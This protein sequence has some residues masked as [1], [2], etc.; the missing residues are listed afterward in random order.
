MS[1][2]NYAD[3]PDSYEHGSAFSV[4]VAAAAGTAAN[5]DPVSAIILADSTMTYPK[6]CVHLLSH[7]MAVHF[8][9]MPGS[10]WSTFGGPALEVGLPSSLYAVFPVFV[11]A[12]WLVSAATGASA[13]V[14]TD[15]ATSQNYGDRL[16]VGSYCIANG[17]LDNPRLVTAYDHGSKTVTISGPWATSP[18]VG[19]YIYFIPANP[20]LLAPGMS[21]LR[22]AFGGNGTLGSYTLSYQMDSSASLDIHYPHVPL[23]LGSDLSAATVTGQVIAATQTN[24]PSI[25]WSA[26]PMT[27][28]GV[29]AFQ[30]S[31][32]D[33]LITDARLTSATWSVYRLADVTLPLA[34]GL[35]YQQ[36]R[37]E[38]YEP[39]G[40]ALVL[41]SR[42]LSN[43]DRRGIIINTLSVGGY[44]STHLQS[45]HGGS[46]AVFAA[47]NPQIVIL[48]YG[49]N[50][51]G[52]PQYRTAQQYYDTMASNID[53]LKTILP[54]AVFVVYAPHWRTLGSNQGEYDLYAGALYQLALNGIAHKFINMRKMLE[55]VGWNS[56]GQTTF[57]LDGAHM[58]ATGGRAWADTFADAFLSMRNPQTSQPF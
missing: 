45:R 34:M 28:D 54:N 53:W 26:R 32:A 6:E 33:G 13:S 8:G 1:F 46:S 38:P 15:I 9:N 16:Y 19:Q 43:V 20:A 35:P 41:T 31:V 30:A 24:C 40:S 27:V 25:A 3:C 44:D 55:R 5:A 10:A 21:P 18:S 51:A 11:G 37:L 39:T 22:A 52:G 36:L 50:D 7:R 58:T 17:D 49:L 29:L 42:L 57:L 2:L 4:S 14:A 47:I 23:A 56:A 48:G 12:G